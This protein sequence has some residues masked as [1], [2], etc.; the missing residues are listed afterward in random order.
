M[1]LK[2]KNS[3]ILLTVILIVGV[4]FILTFFKFYSKSSHPY[5][6]NLGEEYES[7]VRD[8][9]MRLSYGVKSS[10]G[11]VEPCPEV[12][13]I[14]IDDATVENYGKFGGHLWDLRIPFDSLLRNLQQHF[15]PACV[16]FDIIFKENSG[17][18]QKEFGVE[19]VSEKPEEI[20]VLSKEL[21]EYAET[22]EDIGQVNLLRLSTWISEQGENLIGNVLATMQNPFDEKIKKLPTILAY[23]LEEEERYYRKEINFDDVSFYKWSKNEVIGEDPDNL[24]EDFGSKI[25]YIKAISISNDNVRNIPD[26]YVYLPYCN[27]VSRNFI[28]YVKIGFINNPRD[29]DGVVR[30]TPLILATKYYNSAEKKLKTIF[31]PSLSLLSCLTFWGSTVKDIKVDFNSHI[32][33][34]T[35]SGIKHIPIDKYGRLLINY[36]FKPADINYVSFSKINEFGAGL[37]KGGEEAF[38]GKFRESLEEVRNK[39]RGKICII[40]L[41]HTANSDIGPKFKLITIFL[42]QDS[43]TNI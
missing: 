35:K 16:S 9:L 29:L 28:D 34:K 12:T 36:Q 42:N 11:Q 43:I 25:P 23:N 4:T 37:N 39:L 20:L 33:V 13:V 6:E 5:N 19:N 10:L 41:T 3:K 17:K 24:S 27:L 21:K 38:K 26:D 30:R 7:I 18:L 1:V 8:S 14:G 22:F 32:E 2:V 31:V 40:G 15:S